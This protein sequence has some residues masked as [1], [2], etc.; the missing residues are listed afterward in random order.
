MH[1]VHLIGDFLESSFSI[2]V[3]TWQKK[4]EEIMQFSWHDEG[5]SKVFHLRVGDSS[6]F[7]SRANGPRLG[8]LGSD[9]NIWT[10][11]ERNETN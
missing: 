1:K 9:L 5:F 7:R 3:T 2:L 10:P 8:R 6:S 4:K 11:D